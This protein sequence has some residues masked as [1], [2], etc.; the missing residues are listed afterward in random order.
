MI[1]NSAPELENF[2]TTGVVDASTGLAELLTELSIPFSQESGSIRLVDGMEILDP[3][4]ILSYLHE[5]A[6]DIPLQLEIYRSIDST[7][8]TVMK[9]PFGDIPLVCLAEMQKAGRGRRGRGW[10]SPFG[11]NI[12]LTL[13]Q[14]LKGPLSALEGLSL[15][16]GMQVVDTLRE[17]GIRDVGLKWPNDILLEGGKLGGILVEIKP[18]TSTGI[19]V[20]MGVGINLAIDESAAQKIDQPW[21]VISANAE[22][23]RNKLAGI[24]IARLL[25]AVRQFEQHGFGEFAARWNEYNH[26]ADQ[27]VTVIRGEE[28][29]TGI[30]RGVDET[31]NLVLE[32]AVGLQKHN[33]GEVSLRPV[34]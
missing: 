22:I 34:R 25:K 17:L 14:V 18:P 19:G 10:V 13:G 9:A 12:Y 28:T 5:E 32:T 7:N 11:T 30:D 27:T 4:R 31:G 21:S 24:L 15:V 23:S 1:K 20:A 6:G 16:I 2:L 8:D 26:Y 3:E 29:F 33:S